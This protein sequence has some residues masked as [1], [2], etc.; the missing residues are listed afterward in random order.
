MT[1]EIK[2]PFPKTIAWLLRWFHKP[3][4]DD[5]PI[6]VDVRTIHSLV[7]VAVSPPYGLT[8]S[9]L[10]TVYDSKRLISAVKLLRHRYYEQSDYDEVLLY[11]LDSEWLNNDEPVVILKLAEVRLD[12][13]IQIIAEEIE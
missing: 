11:L 12:D 2:E 1:T 8:G 4:G 9:P 3:S 7:I 10:V 13:D 5:T 6:R